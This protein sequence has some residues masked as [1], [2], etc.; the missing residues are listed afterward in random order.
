MSN[1]NRRLKKVEKTLNVNKEQRVAEIV[2]F[3]DG[4][5]P[6]DHTHGNTGYRRRLGQTFDG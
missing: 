2:Q 4:P 1:L 3:C 6:P 5:L